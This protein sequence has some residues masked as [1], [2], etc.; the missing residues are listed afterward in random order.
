MKV[1]FLDIDGV[2]QPKGNQER[3]KHIDEIP[4]LAMTLNQTKQVDF[5]YVKLSNRYDLAAVYYDWDKPSVERLRCMLDETDAQIILS[6]D[7]RQ[8]GLNYM[9]AMLAVHNLDGYLYDS[10]YYSFRF[11]KSEM[12][13]NEARGSAWS[14]IIDQLYKGLSILHPEEITNKW[15]GRAN[16]SYRTCEIREYLDRHREV[17][18][19]VAIDDRDLTKGIED[20][21]VITDNEITEEQMHRC[22]EILQKEDG[23]YPLDESMHTPE[24][25]KWREWMAKEGE[26]EMPWIPVHPLCKTTT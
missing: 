24:L 15:G 22:I 5:D 7:W 9:R 10:T 19:F 8:N 12:R 14:P 6:T 11:Y 17:T 3:F 4:A 25:Q 1:V 18:S 21:F 16:L 13:K 26:W 23:P 20:H 2:L